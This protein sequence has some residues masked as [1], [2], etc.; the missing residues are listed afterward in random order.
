MINGQFHCLLEDMVRDNMAN[1]K[2][3]IGY[4]DLY[5]I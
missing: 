4:I 1:S 5:N 2:V 3:L